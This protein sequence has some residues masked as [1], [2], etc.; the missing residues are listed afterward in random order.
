M[1]NDLFIGSLEYA[2]KHA[3]MQ[4]GKSG[5]KGNGVGQ[6]KRST[7]FSSDDDEE[8]TVVQAGFVATALISKSR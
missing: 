7:L 3:S 2:E 1:E 5:H 4:K 6:R 8:T